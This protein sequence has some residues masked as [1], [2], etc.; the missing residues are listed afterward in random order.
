MLVTTAPAWKSTVA[1]FHIPLDRDCHLA[2]C[3]LARAGGPSATLACA[4]C[5]RARWMHTT[6][7]DTCGQFCWVTESSLTDPQIEQL[8]AISDL[9]R[10]LQLACTQAL[11]AYSLAPLCIRKARQLLAA[12]INTAKREALV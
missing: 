12:T 5:G 11:G 10:E 7:H 9:P 6:R 4:K 3:H 2:S 1:G 8:R